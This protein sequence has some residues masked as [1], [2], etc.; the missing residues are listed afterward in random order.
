MEPLAWVLLAFA[1]GVAVG[2]VFVHIPIGATDEG[3]GY[4]RPTVDAEGTELAPSHPQD[5][6]APVAETPSTCIFVPTEAGDPEA[7]A[8]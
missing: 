3:Q 6:P 2:A 8:E 5:M 4:I 7:A 1:V